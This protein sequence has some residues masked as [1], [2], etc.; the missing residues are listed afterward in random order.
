MLEIEENQRASFAEIY[1]MVEEIRRI[2]PHKMLG[3]QVSSHMNSSSQGN[4]TP[5]RA[6]QN[7]AHKSPKRGEY[8][9][10]LSPFRARPMQTKRTTND[11]T[12]RT[13][14]GA[15]QRQQTSRS[16]LRRELKI[17]T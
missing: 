8:S 3:S 12:G 13:P 17:N 11:R 4:R 10:N 9:N 14:E 2:K 16:P 7:A 1:D 5:N 15:R 6:K